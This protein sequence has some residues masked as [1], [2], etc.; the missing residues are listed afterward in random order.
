MADNRR[1]LIGTP[2]AVATLFLWLIA[3]ASQAA[4]IT[5]GVASGNAAIRV[6]VGVSEIGSTTTSLVG[7]DVTIDVTAQSLDALNI[8]LGPNV[9]LALSSPYGGYD[10]ITIETV[11]LTDGAGYTSTLLSSIGS[12]FQVLV[13]PLDVAGSWGA[14]DSAAVNPP[15]SGVP[16]SFGIPSLLS[17][18]VVDGTVMMNGV[19]LTLLDGAEFGESDPLQII[20]DIQL[21]LVPEPGTALLVGLGLAALSS[22]TRQQARRRD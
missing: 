18:V 20:A 11:S 14:T 19:T 8:V 21:E 1:P 9:P 17:G 5:Y 16:I 6:L 22:S 10:D 15:Q 12:T 2:F 7:G 4:P 13:G 3:P